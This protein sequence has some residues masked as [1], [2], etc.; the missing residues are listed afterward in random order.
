MNCN[1]SGTRKKNSP[2]SSPSG[3]TQWASTHSVTTSPG[4]HILHQLHSTLTRLLPPR[5]L[6]CLRGRR[7]NLAPNLPAHPR[8]ARQRQA[9]HLLLL[10]N[11]RAQIRRSADLLSL[12]KRPDEQRD[13][14]FEILALPLD[15]LRKRPVI[16]P[17]L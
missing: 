11:Q 2:W 10:L 17:D 8:Q 9:Q 16:R 6:A 12:A 7:R 5:R 14:V 13:L 3:I 4:F 15:R 1:C